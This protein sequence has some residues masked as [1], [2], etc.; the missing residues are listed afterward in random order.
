MDAVD[1]I[2]VNRAEGNSE[3]PV[4]FALLIIL[5]VAIGCLI[6]AIE[7]F[8]FVIAFNS[9]GGVFSLL[10]TIVFQI[11]AQLFWLFHGIIVS[12]LLNMYALLFYGLIFVYLMRFVVAFSIKD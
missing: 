12:G 10:A 8:S 11:V 5:N 7:I 2:K 6:V 4:A 9:A 3:H 1:L